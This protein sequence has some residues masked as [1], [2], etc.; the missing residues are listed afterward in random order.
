MRANGNSY[1]HQGVL[2]FQM[3][4]VPMVGADT[5]V[6]ISCSASPDAD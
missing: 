5:C 4:Q 6:S 2:Q 3:F 1:R